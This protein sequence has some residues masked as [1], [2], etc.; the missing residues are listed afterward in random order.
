MPDLNTKSATPVDFEV[1]RRVRLERLK[2]GLSQTALAEQIGVTFQQVQKYE[3]GTNRVAP[4][5]LSQI[6]RILNVPVS[7]FFE[8]EAKQS[9]RQ[10]SSAAILTRPYVLRLVQAFDD[11]P[12]HLQAAVLH[13]VEALASAEPDAAGANGNGKRSRKPRASKA[14]RS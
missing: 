10:P 11:L 5:R 3:K 8:D 12:D 9:N 2:A 7:S 6:A 4:G 1:G 14:L 13:F